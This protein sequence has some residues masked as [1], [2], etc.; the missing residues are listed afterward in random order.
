MSRAPRRVALS[1]WLCAAALGV[2]ACATS[3]PPVVAPGAPRYP[4]YVFPEAGGELGDAET[5]ARHDRAWQALQAGDLGTAER[6]FAELLRR[7][8]GFYPAETGL[9]YVDVAAEAYDDALARFD[10]IF[11]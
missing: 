7:A 9:G 8:P 4:D 5:L 6:G 11:N 10:A 3:P 1:L 2:A